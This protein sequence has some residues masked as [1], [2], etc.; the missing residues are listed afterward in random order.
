MLALLLMPLAMA[1]QGHAAAAAQHHQVA[2]AAQEDCHQGKPEQQDERRQSGAAQCMMACAALP[3]AQAPEAGEAEPPRLSLYAAP[4]IVMSGVA[5]EA[6]TP[7]PR[8]A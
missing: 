7:P 3:V 5:P 8:S 4:I 6:T 1:G 2:A